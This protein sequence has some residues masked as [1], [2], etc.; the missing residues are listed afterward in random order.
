V[1]THNE[2][3]HL[4]AERLQAFLEE[5]L[6]IREH[7]LAG[8]HLAACTQCSAELE[9]WRAMF[10][11]LGEVAKLRPHEGFANR[12]MARVSVPE[13]L[14]L[15]ERARARAASLFGGAVR[16]HVEPELLQDLVE[17]VLPRRHAARIRRHL[18]GCGPCTHEAEGWAR[19]VGTLEALPRH[20]PSAA[21]A[22]QVMAR[23]TLPEA[24]TSAARAVVPSGKQA[25]VARW[26]RKAQGLV[27]RTRRAWAVLSGAAVTPV[28]TLGLVFYAVFSH[29]AL[30]PGALLSYAG[31]Q[32]TD[33]AAAAWSAG[34]G[35]L[36]QAMTAVGAQG[37]FAGMA[38]AP[39]ALAAATTVYS[40][41]VVLALRV[42]YKN[43]V[44]VRSV[45]I[46]HAQ[47]SHS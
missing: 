24:A 27:P 46:R 12:V 11:E 19:V 3:G 40:V 45:G 38:S 30:T 18:D 36:A 41:L 14:S 43:L 6:P 10:S 44:T 25:M 1:K 31:W 7:R 4:S 35:L 17:G 39:L 21:F 20:A 15:G 42:L 5:E 29:P 23:V 47:I 13:P 22:D 16:G 26:L 8:E 9:V 28:A 33:M 37:L 34:W 32:L 2:H